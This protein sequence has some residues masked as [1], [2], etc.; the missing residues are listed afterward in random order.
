MDTRILLVEDEAELSR[1]LTDYLVARGYAVTPVAD[2]HE[3]LRSA[4]STSPDAIL[5]DLAIPGLPGLEVARAIA[6]Q[7]TIPMIIIT[8]RGEE[9][10]R[11]AGFAAGVDDYLVKPFSLPEL[12]ARL[13]AVLRRATPRATAGEA[14]TV[15]RAG[16]LVIDI[17]RHRAIC[18][19]KPLELTAVQFAIL[20]ALAGD[21]HRVWTRQRLLEAFQ[22]DPWEGYER[23]IDVHIKNIRKVL[24]EDPRHPRWIQT[25]RGV[26]YRLTVPEPSG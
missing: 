5:L 25:V 3:A 13:Q 7:T 20:A 24:E 8:A 18:C 15:L 4:F 2:G 23:T 26:G 12:A 6:S 11:L 19:G 9:E 10:D 14:T 1:M 21:P 17:P 22:S 16:D